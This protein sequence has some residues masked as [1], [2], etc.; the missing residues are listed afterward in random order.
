M[1]ADPVGS[2]REILRRYGCGVVVLKN[3]V[4]V[5]CDEQRTVLNVVGS[6]ALA[7]G[8]SGDLL[9]GLTAGLLPT[10]PDAFEAACTACL[11]MGCAG[12]RAEERF[13]VR[14]P[15]TRDVLAMLPEVTR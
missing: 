10:M 14:S 1:L 7:K 6:A 2:A 11:W 15:L 5:I 8:G 3:A 9:A 13:G 12:E 4:T